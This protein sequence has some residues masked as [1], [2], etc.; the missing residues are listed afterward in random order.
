[1]DLKCCGGAKAQGQALL[2]WGATW[3]LLNYEVL[4]EL[5]SQY[6][7]CNLLHVRARPLLLFPGICCAFGLDIQS[8]LRNG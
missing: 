4:I 8:V 2:S 1:M 7:V 3:I 5:T 6:S